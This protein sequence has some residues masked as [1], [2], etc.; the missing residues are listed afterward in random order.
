MKKIYI[1]LIITL[2]LFSCSGKK[3]EI[4]QDKN[5]KIQIVTTIGMIADAVKNIGGDL[6]NV[7]T[8]MGPGIDPHLYKASA[9]DVRRMSSA[10]IIF[11]AGLHLEGKMAE[12][13]E[14]MNKDCDKRAKLLDDAIAKLLSEH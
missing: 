8:L 14:Q 9:G 11:Y 5:E 6:V 12:V 2:F 7:T 4:K 1:L 13:F 3:S 10:N